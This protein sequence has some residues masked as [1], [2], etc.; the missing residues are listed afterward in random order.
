MEKLVHLL[1]CP[2]YFG[3]DS[4][5]YALMNTNFGS[6]NESPNTRW[7]P[8]AYINDK[9]FIHHHGLPRQFLF[10]ADMIKDERALM[11]L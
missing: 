5:E 8:K 7:I 10:E 2:D 4:E 6:L 9:S 1:S 11:K 3:T